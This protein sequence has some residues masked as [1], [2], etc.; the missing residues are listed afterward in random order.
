MAEQYQANRLPEDLALLKA[1]L[2]KD[3]YLESHELCRT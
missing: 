3:Y 2:T 1:S